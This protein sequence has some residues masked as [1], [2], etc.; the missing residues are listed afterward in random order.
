MCVNWED[1]QLREDEDQSSRILFIILGNLS[2][3]LK[4]VVQSL[5]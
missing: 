1:P 4:A 3:I 5:N 2:F